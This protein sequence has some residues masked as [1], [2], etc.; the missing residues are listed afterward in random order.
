VLT[1]AILSQADLL[2][3]E[4]T[5]ARFKLYNTSIHTWSKVQVGHVITLKAGD[6]IF[7]KGH[8]IAHCL[9]FD[10]L[11][12]IGQHCVPHFS[13]NLPYERAHVRQ[14]LKERKMG[15]GTGATPLSRASPAVPS[16]GQ[17]SVPVQA[18]I[19]KPRSRIDLTMSDN[20]DDA[21]PSSGRCRPNSTQKIKLEPGAMDLP[22]PAKAQPMFVDL[23]ISDS[24]ED[25]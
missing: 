12:T 16:A 19:P 13:N 9:D 24:D 25:C 11:L 21:T 23:T 2:A 17:F 5:I 14:V 4:D 22:L 7:L 18:S 6:H 1:T 10:C 3:P 20:D 15:N 8:D